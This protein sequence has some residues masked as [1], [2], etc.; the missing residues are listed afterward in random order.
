MPFIGRHEFPLGLPLLLFLLFIGN[1]PFHALKPFRSKCV[2]PTI[3]TL[4]RLSKTPL[5]MPGPVL[6]SAGGIAFFLPSAL[7][8]NS[9]PRRVRMSF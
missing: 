3:G 1:T 6:R 4:A 5:P 2:R 7:P 8:S 9:G